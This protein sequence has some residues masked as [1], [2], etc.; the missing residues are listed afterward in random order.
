M[1]TPGV[2]EI[3]TV[4]NKGMWGK[5]GHSDVRLIYLRVNDRQIRLSGI[6][7]DKGTA[8]GIGAAA[9]SAI[10]FLPAGSL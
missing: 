9:V 6:A 5:S 7:D 10:V 2:G 1:G 8:G 4:R 3:T